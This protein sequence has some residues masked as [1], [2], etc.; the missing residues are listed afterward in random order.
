MVCLRVGKALCDAY[1]HPHV[2]VGAK[3]E[4]RRPEMSL[5]IIALF[6]SDPFPAPERVLDAYHHHFWGST[7]S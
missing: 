3:S 2:A 5:R 7:P 1:Q 4:N 6:F